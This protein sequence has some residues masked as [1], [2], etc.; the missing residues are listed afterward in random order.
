MPLY[1]SNLNSGDMQ[2]KQRTF[3]CLELVV[4]QL[5]VETRGLYILRCV[6]QTFTLNG[7][8]S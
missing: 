8:T 1:E 3:E 4:N 5:P 7:Y 6:L 2:Q